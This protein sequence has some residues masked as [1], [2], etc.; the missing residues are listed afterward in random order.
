MGRN[1]F[2]QKEIDQI[3]KLL[4]LKCAGTRF[5]QKTVRHKLRV[6]YEFNIADFNVQGKAFGPDELDAALQ[7]GAIL[8]LDDATIEAMKAK[9]ARDRQ[10]DEERACQAAIAA[11]EQTD[12]QEALRQWNEMESQQADGGKGD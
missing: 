8:I 10:R 4:R 9:R 5:Q 1:K 7:R 12:W 11:G 6:E 2:A 3:R